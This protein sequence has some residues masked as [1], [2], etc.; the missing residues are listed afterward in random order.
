MTRVT[1]A[2]C[3]LL[4]FEKPWY[5]LTYLD[6]VIDCFVF[7]DIQSVLFH[8]VKVLDISTF[9]QILDAVLSLFFY[10]FKA[11]LCLLQC[12]PR[13]VQLLLVWKMKHDVSGLTS[14]FRIEFNPAHRRIIYRKT[15]DRELLETFT[16]QVTNLALLVS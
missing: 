11:F 3:H 2:V 8:S 14:T 6:V 12:A 4:A 16:L 5:R 7:V 10:S 15:I 1:L 9:S 13:E